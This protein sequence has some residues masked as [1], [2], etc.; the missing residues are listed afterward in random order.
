MAWEIRFSKSARKQL[1]A[2][3]RVAAQRILA[4]FHT[5]IQPAANPRS[6][7]QALRGAKLGELW[8]YRVGDYRIIAAIEDVELVIMVVRVGHR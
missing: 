6:L 5:R 1:A 7:G 4:F 3:D 2:L 8:K